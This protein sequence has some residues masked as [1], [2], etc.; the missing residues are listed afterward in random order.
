MKKI[1]YYPGKGISHHKAKMRFIG[2]GR[3]TLTD[4]VTEGFYLTDT[5]LWEGYSVPKSN[6]RERYVQHK[7]TSGPGNIDRNTLHI[8]P[9]KNSI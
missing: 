1:Y 4:A 7:N 6:W 9:L 8:L 3:K 2:S 5:T